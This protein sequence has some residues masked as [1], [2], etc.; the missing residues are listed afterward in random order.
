M[1]VQGA[2]IAAVSMAVRAVL[3]ATIFPWCYPDVHYILETTAVTLG[4]QGQIGDLD[5]ILQAGTLGTK[6]LEDS[7]HLA[8]RI[9]YTSINGA[10][11]VGQALYACL[12][13]LEVSH[14]HILQI[15]AATNPC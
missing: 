15:E 9:L 2:V 6:L 7:V 8:G 1:N 10:V 4:V 11:T 5:I 14:I 3:S 12:N 13:L